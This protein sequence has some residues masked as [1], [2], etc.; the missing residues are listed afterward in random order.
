MRGKKMSN[1]YMQLEHIWLQIYSREPGLGLVQFSAAC[2]AVSLRWHRANKFDS[3][4]GEWH[5]D[6]TLGTNNRCSRKRRLARAAALVAEHRSLDIGIKGLITNINSTGINISTETILTN[7]FLL[8]YS[9]FHEIKVSYHIPFYQQ[10]I[11][12][13]YVSNKCQAEQPSFLPFLLKRRSHFYDSTYGD[14][15]MIDILVLP[16]AALVS[17][18]IKVASPFLD[19]ISLKPKA[20]IGSHTECN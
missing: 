15:N 11:I 17:V 12:C 16:M 18:P 3:A 20:P 10:T 2:E 1:V 4:L 13:Y 14:K 19:S 9:S 8:S 7:P 5:G 6:H